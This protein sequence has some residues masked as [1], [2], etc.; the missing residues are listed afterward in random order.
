MLS[1]LRD[2][3]AGGVS[4]A[5]NRVRDGLRGA[6]ER[7]QT[8]GGDYAELHRNIRDY[9][10]ER[11]H[12]NVKALQEAGF[13]IR[14]KAGAQWDKTKKDAEKKLFDLSVPMRAKVLLALRESVKSG[15]VADPDMCRCVKTRIEDLV[16]L[17]WDDLTIT[18]EKTM[19]DA[20]QATLGQVETDVDALA[21]LGT[22]PC[23]LSPRWWRAKLLYHL[24]PFDLS[25]FGNLK[26]PVWLVLMVFMCLPSF[27]FLREPFRAIP[28]R[29]PFFIIYLICVVTGCP[30]DE[31]QLVQFIMAIKGLQFIC[32]GVLMMCTAAYMYYMCVH[33]G[34]THDCDTRGP[35]VNQDLF[36]SVTDWIGTCVLVWV[37][38]L[39]L[40]CSQR[41]AGLRDPIEDQIGDG[42]AGNANNSAGP[43]EPQEAEVGCCGAK[44]WEGEKGGRLR[45]W[46]GYDFCCFL[47]SVA[48]C[49][50]L[51]CIDMGHMRPGGTKSNGFPPANEIFDEAVAEAQKWTGH[52]AIYWARIV[53]AL[54]SFPFLFFWIPGLQGILTHTRITGYNKNGVC[55]PYTLHP[56][57]KEEEEKSS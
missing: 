36:V 34:G 7:L 41:S 32:S 29:V 40:P 45:G 46:L 25:I 4:S 12:V 1:G 55:V 54:L 56:M 39:W 9:V 19:E 31:F 10:V 47:I 50:L 28:V 48:I 43:Q 26:D 18:V 20:K 42:N 38:F 6:Q 35:G 52:A 16:D 51:L 24:L 14:D 21:E 49:Y 13:G 53:Y 23:C 44:R 15:L 2:K 3:V 8:G 27:S 17:F 11:S 33:P 30:A 37:A 5:R 57:P 22:P